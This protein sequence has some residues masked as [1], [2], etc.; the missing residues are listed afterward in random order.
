MLK[1]AKILSTLKVKVHVKVLL[2]DACTCKSV[3]LNVQTD[4]FAYLNP[5]TCFSCGSTLLLR[6]E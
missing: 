4:V 2:L 1:I 5:F 6:I 3:T